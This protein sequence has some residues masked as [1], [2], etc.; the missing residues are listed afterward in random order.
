MAKTKW[1]NLTDEEVQYIIN[2]YHNT[3]TKGMLE[4]LQIPKKHL[5]RICTKYNLKKDDDFV[6]IRKDNCL[7]N[8]QCQFIIDNYATMSNKE[9]CE[10]LN[11]KYKT[12]RSFASRRKLKK[13]TNEFNDRFGSKYSNEILEYVKD[14]YPNTQT[15]LMSK[16]IGLSENTIRNIANYIGVHKDKN[17]VP[18]CSNGVLTTEQKQ[19]II[20]NY[21]YMKTNDI[22]KKLGVSYDIIKSYAS[23]KKLKKEPIASKSYN[24]Y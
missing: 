5:E 9:I 20:D 2:N 23:N 4:K 22:V 7:T 6:V 8:E 14:K 16:E 21:P 1:R 10:I 15:E 19:F 17:Y 12:L 11:I 3:Q 13:E 24:G 18:Y